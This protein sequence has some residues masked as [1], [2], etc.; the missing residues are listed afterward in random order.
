MV[1]ENAF[2]FLNPDLPWNYLIIISSI[3][4]LNPREADSAKV[5]QL[6]SDKVQMKS[7]L[8]DSGE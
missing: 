6:I 4:K 8:S 7:R 1:L 5:T 3:R 2:D